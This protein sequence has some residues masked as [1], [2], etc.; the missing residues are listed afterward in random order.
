MMKFAMGWTLLLVALVSP[1][2]AQQDAISAPERGR[3]AA[4]NVV[5]SMNWR[6]EGRPAVYR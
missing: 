3:A 1:A 5:D 2:F 4:D 6:A